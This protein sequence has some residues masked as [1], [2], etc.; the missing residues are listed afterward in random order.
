MLRCDPATLYRVIREDAFSAVR[1]CTRYFVPAKVIGQMIAEAIETG[2]M[3]AV[4]KM[5]GERRVE[6]ALKRLGH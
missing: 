5:A 3:V 6:R 2:S 1:I 4:A